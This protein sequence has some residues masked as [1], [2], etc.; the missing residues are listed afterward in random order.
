MER[1]ERTSSPPASSEL[2]RNLPSNISME[3]LSKS[4]MESLDTT[5]ICLSL[6]A[7]VGKNNDNDA[8]RVRGGYWSEYPVCMQCC[9]CLDD[10]CPHHSSSSA[11]T[12]MATLTASLC[13]VD[14]MLWDEKVKLKVGLL[15]ELSVG[16]TIVH[17]W[18]ENVLLPKCGSEEDCEECGEPLSRR[19]K[20]LEMQEGG[21]L[22]TTTPVWPLP[23]WAQPIPP[24]A[25][26]RL[27]RAGMEPMPQ[28]EYRGLGHGIPELCLL[29]WRRMKS[30]VK[31]RKKVETAEDSRE[32][33]V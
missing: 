5:E 30:R 21:S 16:E 4:L 23:P 17:V 22:P 3:D 27:Q 7:K 28:V 12:A 6:L 10:S 31:N 8:Q 11:N 15:F 20:D 32:I 29:W 18:V 9:R 25:L 33:S 19:P 14:M 24:D 1:Q 26:E 13:S 2:N